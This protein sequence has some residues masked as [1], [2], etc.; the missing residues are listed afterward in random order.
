[1]DVEISI[2]APHTGSDKG[3]A[4]RRLFY[5]YFNPRSPHGERRALIMVVYGVWRISIHAPHT[6]SDFQ[7]R[8]RGIAH[9][10]SIHAPHTGSDK[11]KIPTK[12]HNNISIHAPHTGSDPAMQKGL[13]ECTNFN[14]RSPHGERP[15]RL[16]NVRRA[17]KFQSTLPTRGAT[18][19]YRREGNMIFISIH[20]PHTGSD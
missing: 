2:H 15:T 4:Q 19:R 13:P 9:L 12:R 1:M 3:G 10:I 11:I 14:P 7:R 20:A 16:A 5:P 18:R 17:R 8:I 6:G